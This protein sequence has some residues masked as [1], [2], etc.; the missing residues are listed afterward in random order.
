MLLNFLTTEGSS[1]SQ[2]ALPAKNI[3]FFNEFLIVLMTRSA[4][5]GPLSVNLE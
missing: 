5:D 2:P 4:T 1:I 3:A